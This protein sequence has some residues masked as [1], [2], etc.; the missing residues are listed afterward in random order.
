MSDMQRLLDIEALKY[1]KATYGKIVDMVPLRAAAASELLPLF[2]PDCIIDFTETAGRC[3]NGYDD[4]LDH[5]G[6]TL[7]GRISWMVHFFTNPTIDIHGDQATASW[8][9]HAISTLRGEP[10]GHIHSYYGRYTD[11][12]VRTSMGWLQ[13]ELRFNNQS[14]E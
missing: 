4:I 3:L 10:K 1:H 9:L 12:Y 8:L 11:T 13:S 7:H 6:K 14:Q 5:F 2:T